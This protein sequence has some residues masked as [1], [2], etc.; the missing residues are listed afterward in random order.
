MQFSHTFGLKK[1]P[2]VFA[3]YTNQQSKKQYVLIAE[4]I[5]ENYCQN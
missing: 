2:F 5:Q 3:E 4:V 1:V